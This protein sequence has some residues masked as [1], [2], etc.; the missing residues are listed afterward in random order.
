MIELAAAR[1]GCSALHAVGRLAALLLP[2]R[3]PLTLGRVTLRDHQAS[4]VMRLDAILAAR[5]VALL[6]DEAGLG[7]TFTALACNRACR[8]VMVVCP[9]ALVAMWRAS[10]ERAGRT[11]QVVSQ[12]RLSRGV[13]L[14]PNLHD[15]EPWLLIVDEAHGFRNHATRRWSSLSALARGSQLLLLSATPIHNRLREL[16]SQFALGL[17]E[18]ALS[19]S[20][21]QLSSLIVRRTA[22]A[23][24]AALPALHVVPPL[25]IG[26]DEACLDALLALPPALSA[27]DAGD[28]PTLVLWGLVRRWASSRAALVTSLKARLRMGLALS[29]SLEDGRWP[30]RRE[31][32]AWAG[33]DDAIQLGFASLLVPDPLESGIDAAELA[34]RIAA[35][36]AALRALLDALRRSSDPDDARAAAL[37]RIRATHP[38]ERMLVFTEHADSAR[39]M[40]RRIERFGGVGLLTGEECRVSGGSMSRAE[41]LR[42]FAPRAHGAAEPRVAERIACL[43]STDLLSEGANLQDASV[44]VH[45]DLPWSPMRLEQRIGRLRR[46][47]SEHATITSWSFA[48]PAEAQRLLR[49]EERLRDKSTTA[50][51]AVGIAGG[52]L[53]AVFPEARL[54]AGDAPSASR[55]LLMEWLE[56]QPGC[57][58]AAHHDGPCLAAMPGS[59]AGAIALIARGSERALVVRDCASQWRRDDWQVAWRLAA[60]SRPRDMTARHDPALLHALASLEGWISSARATGEGRDELSLARTR[61]NALARVERATQDAPRHKRGT[62]GTL[63]ARVRGALQ[64]ATSAGI[65]CEM[66]ELS[67]RENDDQRFVLAL[68]ALLSGCHG[69]ARDERW[70]VE[71]LLAYFVDSSIRC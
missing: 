13:P 53:P 28:A 58:P 21:A 56:R 55:E 42:R 71:V 8:R 33:D 1:S 40:Y 5:G 20:A 62:A 51:R 23:G 70:T 48:P 38:G 63:A 67:L 49:V 65:E 17:G 22:S 46:M 24:S 41:L 31:L 43:V 35:H 19:M 37:Q 59:Q 64:R 9:A 7:K 60:D 44:V 27:R 68:D 61:R 6:A 69:P 32:R 57:D 4:A 34:S 2:A 29:Q 12:E 54:Q 18:A 45:L 25:V 66:A 30:T 15:Q 11:V 3:A 26:E 36:G 10:A 14:F 16:Q 50:A 52:V 47:E 39:A